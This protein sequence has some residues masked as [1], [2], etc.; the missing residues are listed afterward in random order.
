MNRRHALKALA[1]LM[2]CPVCMS[3][4]ADAWDY[5]NQAAW[6]GVCVTGNRQ[7]PVNIWNTVPADLPPLQFQWNQPATKI[8]K[9]TETVKVF[10]SGGTVFAGKFDIA[11]ARNG[12]C[13]RCI[14][15]TRR[16]TA[17]GTCRPKWRRTSSTAGRA[18]W[19]SSPS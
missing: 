17:S 2:A 6:G 9:N 4:R 5:E 19:V 10:F 7:S 16:S 3:L 8:Q 11:W 1:G 18:A 12:R 15:I 13:C 14:S